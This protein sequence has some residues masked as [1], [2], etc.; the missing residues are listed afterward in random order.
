MTTAFQ[1]TASVV[2]TVLNT[3]DTLEECIRSLLNQKYP[4][5]GYEVIVVDGG[6][7]D[8]TQGM[9]EK[10]PIRLIMAP[11][12]TI[13]AG[14]NRGI[15]ASTGE[16]VAITDG[17]MVADQDWLS[18]L[19][20]PFEEA[21]VGA[22]GGPNLTN[23]RS[24][25]F[26]RLVGLLPEECPYVE[27]MQEVDHLLVYT[28]NAAYRREAIQKAQAFNEGARAGE[29]PELNWRIKQLG[30]RLLFNPEARAWH[31]HRTTLRK[32]IRQHW[33]NGHGVGQLS[34]LNPRAFR[35]AKH[36]G[37]TAALLVGLGTLPLPIV[38][39]D[40]A[41]AFIPGMIFVAYVAA[42][43]GNGIRAFRGT[44]SPWAIPPVTFLT[45]VWVPVW[46]VGYLKGRLR[47]LPHDGTRPTFVGT[48]VARGNGKA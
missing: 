21:T 17:D 29:D 48:E 46:L 2:V 39:H 8:G 36:L 33:R 11:G 34:R 43:L 35:T 14:R 23:P 7:Q 3:R 24:P 12:S 45:M 13:G 22:V 31:Y 5:E 26:A 37:A 44:R 18:Q 6:S 42:C 1:P 10:F 9:L 27:R 40:M 30:Y 19:V 15:Q 47:P 4:K 38:L 32:F 16:I 20:A 25:R 28:R 41:L